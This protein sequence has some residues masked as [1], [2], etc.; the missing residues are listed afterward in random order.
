VAS[1]PMATSFLVGSVFGSATLL[2]ES[3][4]LICLSEARYER[5]DLSS[6]NLGM[7]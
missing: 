7:E 1:L 5:F 6:E 3:Y 2:A 4:G